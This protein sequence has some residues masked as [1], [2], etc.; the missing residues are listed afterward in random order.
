MTTTGNIRLNTGASIPPVGYGCWQTARADI[1][2]AARA[3][4]RAFDTATFYGNEQAVGQGI[5][6]AGL[7]P[8]D[9]FPE[10]L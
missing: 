1:A 7:T 5:R 8:E 4:Y 6:D 10:S 9:V 2:T 3:G